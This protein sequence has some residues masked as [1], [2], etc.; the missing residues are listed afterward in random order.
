MSAV[1]VNGVGNDRA[2]AVLAMLAL[3]GALYYVH[4]YALIVMP[5]SLTTYWH[6]FS[7]ASSNATAQVMRLLYT[8]VEEHKDVEDKRVPWNM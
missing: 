5:D 3:I 4:D 1:P 8:K 2:K 6:A 7:N